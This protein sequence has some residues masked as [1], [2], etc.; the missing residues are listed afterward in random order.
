MKCERA[1]KYAEHWRQKLLEIFEGVRSWRPRFVG[2][3]IER[4]A[5]RAERVAGTIAAES[6]TDRVNVGAMLEGKAQDDRG[7]AGV[8]VALIAKLVIV[9]EQFTD[10]AIWKAAHGRREA[11]AVQFERERLR[12]ATIS[13]ASGDL[14]FRGLLWHF[15]APHVPAGPRLARKHF[16]LG[17]IRK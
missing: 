4:R 10:P 1:G 6:A 14:S 13:E 9:Q 12:G 7:V 15:I 8:R 3:E 16:Q 11:Q 5:D 17:D 2:Q